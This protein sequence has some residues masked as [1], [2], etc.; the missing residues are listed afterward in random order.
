MVKIEGLKFVND[1]QNLLLLQIIK[2]N[3]QIK[4]S[5]LSNMN[6]RLMLTDDVRVFLHMWPSSFVFC[7]QCMMGTW[8][9]YPGKVG[10]GG[11]LPSAEASGHMFTSTRRE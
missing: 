11:A 8:Y 4:D 9:V 7:Q 1:H 10:G 2:I 6:S 3:T 5:R